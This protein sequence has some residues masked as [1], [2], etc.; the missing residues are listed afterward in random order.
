MKNLDEK[1]NL[2][3]K[4]RKENYDKV[5]SIAKTDDNGG[6][7][8]SLPVFIPGPAGVFEGTYFSISTSHAPLINLFENIQSKQDYIFAGITIPGGEPTDKKPPEFFNH[9]C[10][11]KIQLFEKKD[12]QARIDLVGIMPA[13]MLGVQFDGVVDIA[14]AQPLEYANGIPSK[15]QIEK[16]YNYKGL[17]S[18]FIKKE[19]KNKKIDN[20]IVDT[21]YDIQDVNLLINYTL[22]LFVRSFDDTAFFMAELDA[23]KR[24]ARATQILESILQKELI[25]EKIDKKVQD[26]LEKNQKE[27]ILREQLRAINDELDGE[28]DELEKF[29]ERA[30]EKGMPKETEDYVLNEINRLKK[31][32]F[33]SPEMGYI[34]N[35][36]D[37]ILEL[38]FKEKTE[39]KINLE[40]AKKILDANHY[41]LEDVKERIIEYLAVLKNT[42]NLS[43][44]IL[45]FVGPPGIGKTSIVKSIA[46]ALNRNFVQMSLGGIS[47]ESLIRGHSRT[48]VGSRAGRIIMGMKNA[49]TVNPVF[50]LDEVDKLTRDARGDPASALLEV[51]DPEQ[52]ARFKDNFLEVEY[53]LSQ[54]LFVA[55]A[56]SKSTIPAPLLDR[57]EVIELTTYT[58]DEKREIAKR[59]LIPRQLERC[60]LTAEDVV[61]TDSAINSVVSDYCIE[62]GV[63][64][65]E[66]KISQ[67]LRKI[68]VKKQTDNITKSVVDKENLFDYLGAP[69]T[70]Q[71]HM[72]QGGNIGEAVGLAWTQVGGTPLLIETAL[73]SGTGKLEFTGKLG[74][75]FAESV[76]LA[77]SVVKTKAKQYG[78]DSNV[79]KK[80]DVH[81]HLPEMAIG[82]DGPSAGITLTTALMS[83]FTLRPTKPH[84]VMTGEITL[85]GRVLPIGGLK[86]KMLAGLKVGATDL[87]VPEAN[88]SDYEE[89]KNLVEGKLNVHFVSNIDQVLDLVLEPAKEKPNSTKKSKS[90][91]NDNK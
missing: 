33:G 2:E 81:I 35:F 64:E 44:Q 87:I 27:M 15:E 18:R 67:I 61:I 79:F 57:M 70:P 86:E 55:T 19:R 8:L 36:L 9:G 83:A 65:L 26:R 58:E 22:P 10:I 68:V 91:K 32:P 38:P 69:I 50:L 62:A 3:I 88:R 54:V 52:N 73:A 12:N 80:T 1:L 5:H 59:H 42:G 43:G 37:T 46:S 90:H 76:K 17:I 66:R 71:L 6:E 49:K 20:N 82:K 14:K 63:R 45:C 85:L 72:Y 23:D 53:D 30:K 47:D 78:I 56:N 13:K 4:E 21:I 77:M 7:Y 24:M 74:K 60:G 48:Y 84:F 29:K 51:L 28:V 11:C 89:N 75:V 25:T 16:A 41:G 40:E 34:R 31:M 39:D